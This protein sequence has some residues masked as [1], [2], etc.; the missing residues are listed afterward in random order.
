MA[1]HKLY[2]RYGNSQETIAIEPDRFDY[3]PESTAMMLDIKELHS[4][5][6][7]YSEADN[8]RLATDFYRNSAV[9]ELMK[10][11]QT[12]AIIDFIVN[13]S[14]NYDI[15]NSIVLRFLE[16]EQIKQVPTKESHKRYVLKYLA[17]KFE[18][19]KNYS[20]AQV[21]AL[22][23]QWH[24]FGDYFVLRR[25]L[26]DSGIMKRLPNGSKYWRE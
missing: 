19:G 3:S 7:E 9:C 5:W 26:I 12:E 16:G 2:L 4:G 22:I 15:V 24:T 25:E 13:R 20:E 8:R 10:L 11:D 6:K 21:N 17:S 23:D 14:K 1:D 18:S